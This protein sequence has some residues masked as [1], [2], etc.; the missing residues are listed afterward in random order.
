MVSTIQSL[1]QPSYLTNPIF[2]KQLVSKLPASGKMA[3]AAKDKDGTGLRKFEEWI[4]EE[5]DVAS[6]IYQPEREKSEKRVL[7]SHEGEPPKSVEKDGKCLFCGKKSHLTDAWNSFLKLSVDDRWTWVRK[8]RVCF[9]CLVANHSI[10]DCKEQGC[11]KSGCTRKHNSLLH[12]N[13]LETRRQTAKEEGKLNLTTV[14]VETNETE[15]V[16]CMRKDARRVYLRILLVIFR[17][18]NGVINTYTVV[19]SGSTVSLIVEEIA[20]KLSLRGPLRPLIALWYDNAT[21]EDR[22]SREVSLDIR[23]TNGKIYKIRGA[24]TIKMN[25]PGQLMT[26]NLK[27]VSIFE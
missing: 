17:G 21:N 15:R 25:M 6:A 27:K 11:N 4:E 7:T 1:N 5:A 24:R 19:D 16:N 26:V 2:V 23:S 8:K 18:P 14:N 10:R 22:G 13:F 9:G 12:N 20:D 3:K